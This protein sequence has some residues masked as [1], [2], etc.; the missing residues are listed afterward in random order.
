MAPT[1]DYRQLAPRV[2]IGDRR[3][4]I[5]P[6][7]PRGAWLLLAPIVVLGPFGGALG[8]G[9]GVVGRLLS[10][11][12]LRRPG[13]GRARFAIAGAIEVAAI[14][15]YAEGVALIRAW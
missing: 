10:A 6:P 8:A 5:V 7:L 2:Q 3:V 14:L 13:G 12:Q 15:L 11:T 1:I 4:L 9:I